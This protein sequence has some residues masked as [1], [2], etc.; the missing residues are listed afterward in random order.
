MRKH[1]VGIRKR[2]AETAGP[3]LTMKIKKVS[4]SNLSVGKMNVTLRVV[5]V[6]EVQS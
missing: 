5:I 1:Y 2:L 4:H 3:L 6:R